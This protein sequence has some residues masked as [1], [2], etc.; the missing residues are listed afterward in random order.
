MV[1][2][3]GRREGRG[4]GSA[5][6]TSAAFPVWSRRRPSAPR[7]QCVRQKVLAGLRRAGNKRPG[8]G[9][10]PSLSL[11]CAEGLGRGR[12]APAAARCTCAHCVRRRPRPGAAAP[13]PGRRLPV[14]RA[15][16]REPEAGGAGRL[17]AR[18]PA[19]GQR[20]GCL[21][22]CLPVRVCPSVCLL[23]APGDRARR[24]AR[25]RTHRGFVTAG[26]TPRSP[27]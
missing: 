6:A 19:P 1:A 2:G 17:P 7:R 27:G 21:S 12:W 10:G 16:L 14:A 4:G 23:A 9:P 11:S 3:G 25:R 5:A 18:P 20:G 8:P 15:R 26:L 24:L 13:K 22:V